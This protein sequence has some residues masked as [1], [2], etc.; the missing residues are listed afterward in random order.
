MVEIE[1]M[2]MD[3][4]SGKKT[5]NKRRL[6]LEEATKE[7]IEDSG[8][9]PLHI[10]KVDNETLNAFKDLAHKEYRGDYGMCLKFL[11]EMY[12]IGAY[13]RMVE[14][15]L[16]RLEQVIK[17]VLE[18][19]EGDT[20]NKDGKDTGESGE[21]DGHPVSLDGKKIKGW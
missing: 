14:V 19:D 6:S 7:L 9:Q 3:K 4:E 18:D 12:Y 21:D 5:I 15:K 8:F 11:L 13:I 2:S 16:E 10:N 20:I 1:E 17:N